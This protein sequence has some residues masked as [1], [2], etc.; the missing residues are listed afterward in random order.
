MI[1]T[2]S[3]YIVFCQL[4]RKIMIARPDKHGCNCILSPINYLRNDTILDSILTPAQHSVDEI[5]FITLGMKVLYQYQR[6]LK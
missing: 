6:I 4:S 3:L 5:N 1:Y 2:N